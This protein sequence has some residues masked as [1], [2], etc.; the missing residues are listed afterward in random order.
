[1]S[2]EGGKPSQGAPLSARAAPAAAALDSESQGLLGGGGSAALKPLRAKGSGSSSGGGGGSTPS[3]GRRSVVFAG[4]GGVGSGR[5]GAWC[6]ACALPSGMLG[7]MREMFSQ[8][9]LR[10]TML[11]SYVWFALSFGWY[12]LILWIPTLFRSANV[13]LDPYQVRGAAWS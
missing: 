2:P 7:P 11:L 13:D 10:T 6:G 8:E 12:G 4:G 5:M 1:M 9:H 3:K